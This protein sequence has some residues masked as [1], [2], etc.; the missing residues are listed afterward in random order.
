MLQGWTVRCKPAASGWGCTDAHRMG[1][2]GFGII[3]VTSRYI[4]TSI[5]SRSESAFVCASVQTEGQRPCSV[6]ARTVTPSRPAPG[7]APTT[8]VLK[9]PEVRGSAALPPSRH[10]TC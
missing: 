2:L 1:V 4:V 3:E 7:P 10:N 5:L 8:P 9:P 6:K